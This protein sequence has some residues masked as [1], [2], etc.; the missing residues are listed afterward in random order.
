MRSILAACCFVLGASESGAAPYLGLV[1]GKPVL[2]V[3]GSPYL[4]LGAQT[5]N[6]SSL[7]LEIMEKN[8]PRLVDL[9]VNTLLLPIVWKQVEPEEGEFDFSLV[10][11]LI[12]QARRHDMK[13]V[14]LWFG[15]WKNYRS[16]CAPEW[17]LTDPGRFPRMRGKDGAPTSVLSNFS[18]AVLAADTRAFCRFISHLKAVDG[19]EN[20]VIMVQVQNEI[21]LRGDSRDRSAEANRRFAGPVPGT[22][23]NYLVENREKLIPHLEALWAARGYASSGS[24]EEVFGDSPEGE[25]VFMA[26]HYARFIN[27]MVEQA[28]SIYP[29]PMYV[30]AWTV[31]PADPKPGNHPSGG[32]VARVI[33]IW[34]AGAP[35][36]DMMA[37][38]NYRQDYKAKCREFMQQGN[39]LFVPEACAIWKN[40]SDSAPAKAFYT[41]GELHGVGF[42]P[43]GVDH[44]VYGPE[45][46]L[47]VAYGAL[48][49]MQ[50][51]LLRYYGT[52]ELRA[53]FRQGE[54]KQAVLDF[55]DYG[56]RISYKDQ[57]APNYG[58]II[59]LSRNEFV[60]AGNGA[61]VRFFSQ[62][63]AEPL[64]E[65]VSV[66]EGDFVD[67]EWVRKRLLCGD[68]ARG[69]GARLPPVPYW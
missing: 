54:E 42:A 25:E 60:I 34:K 35:A 8:Y 12:G 44:D 59:R 19:D 43:F 9:N 48:E 41:I 62:V 47:G 50:P 37:V 18:E 53:F 56:C 28:K 65:A 6:S 55:G 20:T 17:V 11:A 3:D 36:I 63:E 13:L 61:Q 14:L 4:I 32:P 2:H 46:P 66:E 7:S 67:G 64:V 22:L 21:G 38:D 24:W 33:D 10:D 16:F 31:D 5:M 30:N 57:V 69:V 40:D 39:P 45:H 29:I 49:K 1:N 58:L 51:L 26:W 15:S 27:Q 68:E 23:M 52:G